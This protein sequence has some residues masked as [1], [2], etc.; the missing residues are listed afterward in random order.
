MKS[1][2]IRHEGNDAI[3]EPRESAIPEPGPGQALL[4]VRAASLNRGDLL[5]AIAFHRAAAGRPAGVDAAGEVH[6]VGAGVAGLKCGDRVMARSR[7]CFAEYVLVDP[8]LATPIPPNLTWVQ[9]AAIPISYVTAWEALIQFGRLKAGE[10]LLVAG[11]SSGVG[12]AS[13]QL[14]KMLGAGVIGVSGSAAKLEKLRVLGLDVGIHARGEDFS[15]RV[16]EA[17][18]GT[19][20]DLAVNL[21]GGTVF[22]A[23]QRALANF[24][25]LAVVGYVDGVMKAELDLEA[26]HGK[27]LEIFG[28]SNAPLTPA[29]R[30]AATRG[31]NRDVMPAI[32]AGRIVP[33]IDRVF[34]F[35][36]LPLA[37]AYV[38]SGAQ[39]GKVVVSLD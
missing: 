39:I 11:A 34:P 13:I 27:R 25:R 33:V 10:W 20:A 18:G 31:F 9:A 28:I 22:A 7:G 35:D 6:A 24:G 12:V 26:A 16:L 14:G 8:A 32:T 23:C 37:K 15:E 29:M 17:T 19:G 21:V 1:Y 4:R 38:E 5:G 30:A 2:W 36:Q 3:L